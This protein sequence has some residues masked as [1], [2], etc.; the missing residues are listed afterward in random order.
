M[1]PGWP[2]S[3]PDLNPQE[4]VWSWAEEE[5][6]TNLVSTAVCSKSLFSL[7]IFL[8]VK[9]CFLSRHHSSS[10]VELPC[11]CGVVWS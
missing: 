3:S 11:L 8:I 10:R 4:N 9:A 2:P 5:V 7:F 6:R 1:L